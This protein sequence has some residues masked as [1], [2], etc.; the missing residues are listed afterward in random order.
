LLCAL[1]Q[2]QEIEEAIDED[3]PK[4]NDSVTPDQT[5]I[6]ESSKPS[7]APCVIPYSKNESLQVRLS[8][9]SDT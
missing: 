5:I 9:L 4:L 1:Q 7:Q 6:S 8:L 3:G 2:I